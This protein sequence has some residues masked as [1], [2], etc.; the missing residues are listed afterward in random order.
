[1]SEQEDNLFE[2]LKKSN[3]ANPDRYKNFDKH[4]NQIYTSLKSQNNKLSHLEK[5]TSENGI[6]IDKFFDLLK[7]DPITGE[8]GLV[9]IIKENAKAIS[10]IIHNKQLEDL[11]KKEQNISNRVDLLESKQREFDSNHKILITKI[12]QWSIF[13]NI[14]GGSIWTLFNFYLKNK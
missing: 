11:L 1:M 8:K 13:I 9:Y 12:K 14:A 5:K 6:K 10:E 3:E 4:L 7:P 2:A